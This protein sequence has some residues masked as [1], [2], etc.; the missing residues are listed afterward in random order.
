MLVAVHNPSNS[1]LEIIKI[2]VPHGNLKVKAFDYS[3]K[4]MSSALAD[5]I[6]DVDLINPDQ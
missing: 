2:A 3:N 5:V 4:Q 1:K 6:C